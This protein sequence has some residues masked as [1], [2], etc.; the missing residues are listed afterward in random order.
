MKQYAFD[1]VKVREEAVQWIRDE[2]RSQKFSKVVVGISGGKDSTVV[3]ALCCRAL[4]A[5]NVHGILMPNGVQPDIDDSIEVCKA[6]GIE[7]DT[8][9]IQS[10]FDAFVM[11]YAFGTVKS[12]YK[13]KT[14]HMNSIE[15]IIEN[16]VGDEHAI[17][18]DAALINLAPRIRMTML[19]LWGQSNHHRL[20]GTSNLSEITVGYCTK[21]GDTSADLNPIGKLT[22]I[23]VVNIGK[24]MD[25]I[26]KHLIE[27]VPADGL[28]GV[29]DEEK[30]GVTY[31]S[32]H[33]YI[34]DCRI[35][36]E[37]WKAI[38]DLEYNGLHKRTKVPMFIPSYENLY[39]E[40]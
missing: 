18:T 21:D 24:T 22:S 2:A 28:S 36:R 8:I 11:S 6:L 16:K 7:Y 32:I 10:I 4:G 26:P 14:K 25:E 40:V 17:L 35:T 39:R 30:M 5:E 33:R 19:R 13:D 37:E 23:E 1:A 38:R 29:P 27:K 15:E 12:V 31:D 3:A 20:C 9:N 34:R